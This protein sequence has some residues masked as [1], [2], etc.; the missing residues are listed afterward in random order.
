MKHN[1]AIQRRQAPATYL[2]FI[3]KMREACE[4]KGQRW[5]IL[6]NE[7]GLPQSG[8]DWDLRVLNGS[9]QKH[10]PGTGGFAVD[11]D[12]QSLAIAAGWPSS[13]L[14][15]T[16][17]LSP[18][19]QDVV[20]A[21]LVYRCL[22]G[23][24][25][26][27]AQIIARACRQVLS[28]TARPPWEIRPEDFEAVL[29]LKDW[30]EKA[31]RDFASVGKIFD[32]NLLSLN[33]P[34]QPATQKEGKIRLAT[35]LSERTG[36]E[37]LPDRDALFELVRIVF[38][39]TAESHND[40]IYFLLVRLI[41]LTGLR[42]AEVQMLPFDCLDWQEHVDV[43]TGKSAKA[44]GGVG[45]SL[46]LKY[47][48][49]KHAE[50]TPDILVEA[51]QWVPAK[52][53]AELVR[54]V[55]EAQR[56]T[57]P[58]RML[59]K[60]QHTDRLAFPSSDLR[61][62]RTLAG[63]NLDTSSLLFLTVGEAL[64]HPLDLPLSPDVAINIPFGARLYTVLG[65][66]KGNGT[67]SYFRKYGRT[68]GAENMSIKP[69]ALRHLLNTELF[70]LNVPDTVITHQFG[71]STV[72]QSYEYDHRSLAEHLKFVDLPTGADATIPMGSTQELVARM[73]VSGA[74]SDSHLGK[75]F[76]RIQA[77]EGDEAAFRYLAAN[78]D[79]F[80]VTPYGF[81]TNS[82][83][84]SPCARHLKCF[85]NC[86]HFLPS[87]LPQHVVTLTS[88]KV[89]LIRMRDV[90]AAKPA[91]TMGR[92]N[93]MAHAA[94]LIDGVT[95]ALEAQPKQRIFPNGADHSAPPKDVFQ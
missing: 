29:A 91:N 37:K 15:E 54:A 76:K 8:S 77:K 57:L 50:G 18:D 83:S 48:A 92:R 90:A 59:L 33:C 78:S 19:A 31:R 23:N 44:I 60:Q 58:L 67:V 87:G 53:E 11:A 79:G 7:K 66:T 55:E 14:P 2:E 25:A 13:R 32:E 36:G 70:R 28:T 1:F 22:A 34:V 73:V 86:K 3:S 38:Q 94:Q 84:V 40:A 21:L 16:G 42:V 69:H 80:H 51:Y 26:D 75:T 4:A 17:S 74:V 63:A 85:D 46:R 5:H 24:T 81:C 62:F 93:Q 41:I 72:A 56:A 89:K 27:N 71:R 68:D 9:H 61:E 10:R 20:K 88:L 39:E 82:F 64:A 65:R 45:R 52:F 35:S 95:R 49:G 43:V 12:M 6:L 47:F 30:S